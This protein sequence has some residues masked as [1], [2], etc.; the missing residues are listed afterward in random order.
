MQRC[1]RLPALGAC[2][3]AWLAL[4]PAMQRWWINRNLPRPVR[5]PV[6]LHGAAGPG[7]TWVRMPTAMATALGLPASW[8]A[9]PEEQVRPCYN[10]MIWRDA[11]QVIYNRY[12]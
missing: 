1:F 7:L 4:S 6:E 8:V 9:V 10:A 3:M 5:L 2:G 12:G 11:R